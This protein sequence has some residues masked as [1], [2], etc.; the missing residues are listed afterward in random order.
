[1]KTVRKTY[2]EYWGYYWRVTHR[3]AIPGILEW[4]NRLVDLVETKCNLRPGMRVLDLGCGG[5]DQARVFSR[6]GYE[7]VGLDL[8]GRLIEYAI[9][10]FKDEGLAA[11][12]VVGDMRDIAYEQEFDLCVIFS[13]TFNLFLSGGIET[14]HCGDIKRGGEILNNRI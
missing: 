5:G 10:S 1:M 14:A 9:A 13:G 3:H 8:S 12:F 7:V 11:T 6:K 2:D 4:D